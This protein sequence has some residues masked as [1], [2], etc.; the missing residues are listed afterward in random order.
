[1]EQTHRPTATLITAVV[2]APAL[3][4]LHLIVSY[5]LAPHRCTTGSDWPMHLTTV[6]A[7][8]GIVAAGALAHRQVRSG[9]AA[10]AT[11][12]YYGFVVAMTGLVPLLV[13][14]C[15]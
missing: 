4:F 9:G 1:M 3:W 15:A 5:A 10:M 8:G 13:E 7:I 12:A 11:I 14:R 6:L 2:A